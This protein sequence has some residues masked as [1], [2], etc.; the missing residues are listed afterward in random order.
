MKEPLPV[1]KKCGFIEEGRIRENFYVDGKYTDTI[2]MGLLKKRM[3]I[4]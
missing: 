1:I 3:E 4:N 2:H